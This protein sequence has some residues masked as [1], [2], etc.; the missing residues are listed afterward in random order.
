MTTGRSVRV[1]SL[2]LTTLALMLGVMSS[3]PTVRAQDDAAYKFPVFSIQCDAFV[4]MENSAKGEGIPPECKALAGVTI[5]AYD[6]ESTQLA[7]CTTDDNGTCTLNISPNGTRIF[8]QS[9]TG[10]PDGYRP[11]SRIERVFTY[12]EFA[13]VA[14]ENYRNDVFPQQDYGTGTVKVQSRVCPDKYASDD[15]AN[16]CST[17]PVSDQWIFANDAYASTGTDGNATIRDVPT[18]DVKLY[19]GQSRLTGDIFFSCY[20]TKDPSQVLKTS[21]TVTAQY[22]A[23]TRDF[24]GHVNLEPRQNIT[25]LWYEIPFLDRGLWDTAVNPMA[26]GDTAGTW[27]SG[28]GELT[29]YAT[30]C[31]AGFVG[32]DLQD[33]STN[34]TDKVKDFPVT[35][36]AADGT[37]LATGKTNGDGQVQLSLDG[38]PVTDFTIAAADHADISRDTIGC[39]ANPDATSGDADPLYQAVTTG[40]GSWS[41]PG[42]GDDDSGL[43]CF[44]YLAS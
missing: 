35:I 15:F 43:L 33:A 8:V 28:I 2:A 25:C 9:T 24:E 23:I 44:W 17:L 41:I 40:D 10:I 39:F 18:G 12:T 38:K 4:K 32:K 37:E 5:T 34:C 22:D 31:P 21:V 30:G 16:D 6:T 26:T 7:N 3:P 36:T 19:G 1:W 20:L 14:F 13:E 27:T 42:F 11:V 29:F